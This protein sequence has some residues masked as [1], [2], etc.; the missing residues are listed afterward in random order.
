MQRDVQS[1]YQMQFLT[2]LDV[3]IQL[4]KSL[5]SVENTP[6]YLNFQRKS[7]CWFRYKHE[8][9]NLNLLFNWVP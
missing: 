4:Q 1:Q 9:W 2:G 5:F 3:P 8:T 7:V 6:L